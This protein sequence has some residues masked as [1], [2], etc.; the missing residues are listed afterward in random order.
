MIMN[1]Y[2]L[3]IVHAHLYNGKYSFLVR[4][5]ADSCGISMSLETPQEENFFRGGSSHARGKRPAAVK[6]NGVT[7]K[8]L[9][10]RLKIIN[11]KIFKTKHI[12][13]GG[14]LVDLSFIWKAVLIVVAGTFFL[15]VAGRKSVSQ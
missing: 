11:N 7:L 10:G 1:V 12:I 15:R 3:I 8:V 2:N 13:R 9:L 14:I 6:G 5:P 4:K